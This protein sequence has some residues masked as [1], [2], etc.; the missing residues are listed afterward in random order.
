MSLLADPTLA[1]PWSMQTFCAFCALGLVLFLQLLGAL[2]RSA[3]CGTARVI[4]DEGKKSLQQ[5][6]YVAGGS[7]PLDNVM[8]ACWWNPIATLLPSW[9]APNLITVVGTI[10]VCMTTVALV[11]NAPTFTESAPAMVY[12]LAALGIFLYQTLDAIDGKQARAT[13][14][15]SPLGQICDHGCDSLA[16]SLVLCCTFVAMQVGFPIAMLG[17]CLTNTVFFLANWEEL[18]TGI[19]RTSVGPIGVTEGQLQAVFLL[20]TCAFFGGDC[21]VRWTVLGIEVRTLVMGQFILAAL[22]MSL[23]ALWSTMVK[24]R[25]NVDALKDL[26]PLILVNVAAALAVR[27]LPGIL[28][29]IRTFVIGNLFS[30][31]SCRMVLAAVVHMR[32]PHRQIC[33]VTYPVLLVMVFEHVAFGIGGSMLVAYERQ[34]SYTVLDALLLVITTLSLLRFVS[35]AACELCSVLNIQLFRIP[36][37]RD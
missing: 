11:A 26:A 5:Y 23:S 31:I 30:Y 32:F 3:T 20:L 2:R 15:S 16:S 13:G 19:L 6:K 14:T 35:K 9:L 8:N 27:V 1:A 18:W 33:Y 25:W 4:S 36:Y 28:P 37:K 34:L 12:G 10:G 22:F 29:A 7:T 21:F 24:T 17:I